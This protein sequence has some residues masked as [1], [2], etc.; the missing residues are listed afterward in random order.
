[1]AIPE[2]NGDNAGEA[3]YFDRAGVVNVGAIAQLAGLVVSPRPHR[4]V[5]GQGHGIIIISRDGL[6]AGQTRHHGWA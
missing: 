1:M 4:A 2:R 5:L 3:R 6:D